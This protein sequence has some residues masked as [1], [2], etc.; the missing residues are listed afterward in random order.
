MRRVLLIVIAL[1]LYG[2]LYPW[3]FHA[4]H[5]G[6]SPLWMLLHTWPTRLTRYEAWDAAVNVALYVPL[7]VF[8]FL[9]VSEKASRALRI[10][11]PL[12][13]GLV[14]SVTV[15]LLQFFDASRDTS[16]TDVMTNVTGA[17]VGMG[18][19]ALYRVKL[20][21]VFEQEAAAR[22]LHP[23]GAL[24]LLC[25]WL[26]YQT[27]PLFPAWGRTR[28][29]AKLAAMGPLASL[30]PV[31]TLL[32][33]AEWLAVACL[34][35]GMLEKRVGRVLAVLLLVLPVR[36]LLVGRTLA[37][38]DIAGAVLAFAIWM[39][40][41]RIY[42][43]RAAPVLLTAALLLSELAP[44][45]FARA[46]A[47]NW[48]PFRSL[49]QTAWQSGFLVLCRKSFWYGSAIWL[50]RVAGGKLLWTTLAAA[51]ALFALELVQVYLP[52]RVPDITDAALAVLMGV[53]LG[54]LDAPP[55]A[56]AAP[57]VR[58]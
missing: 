54:L 27:F 22:L 35:E 20:Q 17:A 43:R 58:A 10:L 55:A 40:A 26:G 42:V 50:W 48:V 52:G 1:I 46:A 41:P 31:A 49:F 53:L 11:A 3:E 28:L 24:L 25:C 37:W 21:R 6:V 57:P 19:G 32:V 7:G 45:H 9:A 14:L 47:F 13:L 23:S 16:M 38:P 8:G 39:W 33:V 4:R 2:S 15:E 5:A 44:L 51:A 34:L 36:L 12:L 30:S 29:A 18:F 56:A